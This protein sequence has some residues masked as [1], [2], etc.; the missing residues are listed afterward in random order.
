MLTRGIEAELLPV[1]ERYGMGTLVWSPLA[2]GWLSGKYRVGQDLPD[3]H[4]AGLAGQGYDLD[5]PNVAA[6]LH[7]ADALGSLADD[8]GVSLVHLAIAFVLR[9]PG[10][11]SAIIGPRT[12]EQLETQLTAATLEL[13]T[14]TLDRIDEIVPPGTNV[15]PADDGLTNY[16]LAPERRRR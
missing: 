1:T 5:D 9:H 4:R 11:T 8:L 2:G 7:A 10:V 12:M 14:A 15:N 16:W 13:D 6:K 3:T